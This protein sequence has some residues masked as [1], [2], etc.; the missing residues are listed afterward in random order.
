MTPTISKLQPCRYCRD[1][2]DLRL[3]RFQCVGGCQYRINCHNC[4]TQGDRKFSPGAARDSWNW[5]HHG[6]HEQTK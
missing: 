3:Q 4:G 6:R 2:S 1:E 5:L